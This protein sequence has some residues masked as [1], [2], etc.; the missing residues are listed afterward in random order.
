MKVTRLP[1]QSNNQKELIP[2]SNYNKQEQLQEQ[3]C[4]KPYRTLHNY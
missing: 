1:K 4:Y 3:Y 2:Q